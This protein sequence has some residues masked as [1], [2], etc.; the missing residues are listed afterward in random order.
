MR[1]ASR[2]ARDVRAARDLLR[3]AANDPLATRF[4]PLRHPGLYLNAEQYRAFTKER[5]RRRLARLIRR[6]LREMQGGKSP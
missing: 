3:L 2:H 4:P 6:V 1:G 5:R